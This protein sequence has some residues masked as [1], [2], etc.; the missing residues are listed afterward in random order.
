MGIRIPPVRLYLVVPG[1]GEGTVLQ[2][3]GRKVRQDVG[4]ISGDVGSGGECDLL[5]AVATNGHF[6]ARD[7]KVPLGLVNRTDWQWVYQETYVA[8]M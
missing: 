5:V 6:P 4:N 8:Q 1:H 7:I 2:L 3:F